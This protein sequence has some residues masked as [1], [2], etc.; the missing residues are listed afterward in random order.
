MR[1]MI[2]LTG[3]ISELFTV[4]LVV[5]GIGSAMMN[6]I[7]QSDFKVCMLGAVIFGWITTI[8]FNLV[9]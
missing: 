7:Q 2:G 9:T 1:D 3:A 6:G 5:W 4:A 8:C